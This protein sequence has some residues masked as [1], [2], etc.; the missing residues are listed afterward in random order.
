MIGTLAIAYSDLPLLLLYTATMMLGLA[1]RYRGKSFGRWHHALFFFTCAAYII[2]AL[3]DLRLA[4]AP[5]AAVLIAMPL[6]RPRRSRRH[7]A[8]AVLGLLCMILLVATA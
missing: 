4:H 2:S 5:A 6:T 7:D 3:G 8:L 1:A